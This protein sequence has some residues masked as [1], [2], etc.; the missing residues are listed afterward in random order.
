VQRLSLELGFDGGDNFRI[1]VTDVENAETAQAID[2]FFAVHV[3]IAVRARIRPF[4]RSGGV[5]DARGFAVFEEARVDV[6]AEVFDRFARNP[7]GIFRRDRRLFNQ[8]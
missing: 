5:V 2:V 1:A 4:D 8:I 3:A 6:I 7:R